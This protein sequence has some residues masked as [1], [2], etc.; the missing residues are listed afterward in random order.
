MRR[1]TPAGS[2]RMSQPA[3]RRRA[4]GRRQQRGEH[5]EAS[6]TCRRRSGRGR[7]RARPSATWEVEVGDGLDGLLLDAERLGEASGGDDLVRSSCCKSSEAIRTVS[8]RI[9]EIL[10]TWPPRPR[11]PS[12]CSN[13]LQSHRHWPARE[14]VDRL[15]V[16]RAHAAPRRRAPARARLRHRVACAAAPA[17][18]GSR[19]APA[20]PPLLLTD[21]EGVAIAVGLRSQATAGAARRRAHDA[22]RPREDRAGA[23]ARA[24]PPHRRAAVARHG[25]RRRARSPPAARRP[26]STPSCSACSPSPAATPS[27][28]ASATRM[29]RARPPSRV[30]EPYRLVPVARRWY[31]LAWDRAARGL[32]HVPARPHQRRVPDARALRAA[33]DERRGGAGARRDRAAL[34]RPQRAGPRRRSTCRRPTSSTHLGWYG[35]DVVADGAGR[36]VWPLEADTVENLVMALMWV[37]RG[38][39]LPRRG[40]AR[41]ARVPRRAGRAVRRSRRCRV[42]LTRRPVRGDPDRPAGPIPRTVRGCGC[43]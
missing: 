13:L 7:R 35:R 42:E 21:D 20:L 40:R 41:G 27:G 25:R 32:A 4:R 33:A 22:Q 28:C 31:L 37:P 2:R 3:T 12:S 16:T 43:G 18:T 29:P 36:C 19:P 9:A 23:A 11:G 39:T 34:A 15:G 6:S 24:A 1:R 26:R 14:L 10:E 5:A 38:A 8:V 17:A 30:V